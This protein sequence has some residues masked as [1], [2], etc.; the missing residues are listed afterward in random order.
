[1]TRCNQCTF[2]YF[3]LTLSCY[4]FGLMSL[5]SFSC[6]FALCTP[7]LWPLHA[8][9]WREKIELSVNLLE[10]LSTLHPRLALTPF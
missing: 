2:E 3:L 1:M 9:E 6:F 5:L 8:V 7:Q 4:L 10:F